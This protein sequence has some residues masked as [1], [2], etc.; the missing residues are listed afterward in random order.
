[1]AQ[2]LS[3]KPEDPKKDEKRTFKKACT[4]EDST[5]FTQKSLPKPYK[6]P[7][8]PKPAAGSSNALALTDAGKDGCALV[9]NTQSAAGQVVR[10]EEVKDR[11]GRVDNTQTLRKL[12]K[13]LGM[14]LRKKKGQEKDYISEML[15]DD[16]KKTNAGRGN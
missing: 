12:E 6:P 14:S 1:M 9:V 4:E 8:A 11:S 13:A 7:A 16:L 5:W 3:G 15:L 10:I 2:P